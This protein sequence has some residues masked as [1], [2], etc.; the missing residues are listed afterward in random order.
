LQSWGHYFKERLKKNPIFFPLYLYLGFFLSKNLAIIRPKK[1]KKNIS[2]RSC[3][4]RQYKC[5]ASFFF[6]FFFPSTTALFF[7]V[8]HASQSVSGHLP[9]FFFFGEKYLK[10]RWIKP[11]AD[12]GKKKLQ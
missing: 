7:L 12:K 3:Y 10:K 6:S 5:V 8:K 2:A 1:K 11:K 9:S 4:F